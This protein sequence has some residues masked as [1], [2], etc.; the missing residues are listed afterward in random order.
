MYLFGNKGLKMSA[1]KLAAQI[2]HAAVQA[3]DGSTDKMRKEW[4]SG[5][6]YTKL[7]M[8]ARDTEHMWVI[9]RY[10]R[11]RGFK[12]FPIIDEGR[13]EVD[14][15]SFTAL[16]VECVD[17]NEQHVNDTFSTFELYK[18]RKGLFN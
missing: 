13:T 7:V 15:H 5:G 17:K 4:N 12:T 1:G 18:E 3:S 14:P 6:H 11:E 16:G 10:L 9:D 2:A 8:Q